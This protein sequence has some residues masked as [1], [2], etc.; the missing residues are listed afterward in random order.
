MGK[1]SSYSRNSFQ[2]DVL[3]IVHRLPVHTSLSCSSQ[4]VIWY[5]GK[6]ADN[7]FPLSFPLV[8]NHLPELFFNIGIHVYLLLILSS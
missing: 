6:F 4:R 2:C 7:L 8:I 1:S 5:M 3:I